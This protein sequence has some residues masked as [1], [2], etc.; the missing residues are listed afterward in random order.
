MRAT[1]EDR[2]LDYAARRLG[3]APMRPRRP[4]EDENIWRTLALANLGVKVPS[5]TVTHEDVL[6]HAGRIGGRLY[7]VT[8]RSR[9]GPLISKFYG[10]AEA[11]WEPFQPREVL[12]LVKFDLHPERTQQARGAT[13]FVPMD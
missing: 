3:V 12:Q 6:N 13:A 8:E 1:L 9:S 11:C 10:S 7:E 2:A 4:G 5:K